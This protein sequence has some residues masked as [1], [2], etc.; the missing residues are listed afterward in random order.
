[1]CTHFICIDNKYWIS[2]NPLEFIPGMSSWLSISLCYKVCFLVEQ[3]LGY[4]AQTCRKYAATFIKSVQ[5]MNFNRFTGPTTKWLRIMVKLS[6]KL[7]ALKM[8]K[9]VTQLMLTHVFPIHANF[10]LLFVHL[11]AVVIPRL[12][13]L[14]IL[15]PPIPVLILIHSSC[16]YY[17][18]MEIRPLLPTINPKDQLLL[19][20]CRRY[21]C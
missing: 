20:L 6:V 21:A 19:Y 15:C 17:D 7:N 8:Q 16:C 10:S 14:I 13:L 11:H 5:L 3:V 4:S 1:M 9:R 18:W 2:P 12:F